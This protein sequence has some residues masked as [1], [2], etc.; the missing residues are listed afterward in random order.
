MSFKDMVAQ[1]IHRVFLNLAEYGEPR[2]VIYDGNV[3]ADIPVVLRG[4]KEDTREQRMDDHVQ[5]LYIA[6]DIMH[7]SLSDIGGVLPEKGTRIRI[8]DADKPEY[9]H[10]YYVA[11]STIAM[12]MVRA[13]LEAYDE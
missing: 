12:G 4:I 1:D 8:S 10:E 11:N 7:C 3:Y 5:G 6:T 13:E 9:Y 2:T